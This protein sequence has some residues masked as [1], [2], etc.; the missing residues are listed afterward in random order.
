ME[1]YFITALVIFIVTYFMCVVSL[2]DKHVQRYEELKIKH[3]F[4][5]KQCGKVYIGNQRVCKCPKCGREN[6]Y[7]RF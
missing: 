4:Y 3:V 5:C 1:I 2:E 7:L 6:S